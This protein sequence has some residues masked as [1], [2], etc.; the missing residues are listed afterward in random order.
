MASY[1]LP[2]AGGL[3]KALSGT[4]ADT[5]TIPVHDND[6]DSEI[7]IKARRANSN[8][9]Y[10][11]C[12][13][14]AAVSAADGTTILEPGEYRTFLVRVGSNGAGTVSIVGNG[15]TYDIDWADR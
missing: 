14:T 4:T 8:P 10:V 15:D 13:G 12:D 11:R 1:R 7:E 2:D 9:I 3:H 5:I 6:Q